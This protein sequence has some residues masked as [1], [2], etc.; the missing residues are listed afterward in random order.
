[1]PARCSNDLAT[2]ASSARVKSGARG[3]EEEMRRLSLAL[4]PGL[5]S[6]L[7]YLPTGAG[8]GKG[9]PAA[10]DALHLRRRSLRDDAA[11]HDARCASGPG[12]PGETDFVP[13]LVTGAHGGRSGPILSGSRHGRPALAGPPA[14]LLTCCGSGSRPSSHSTSAQ[15]F[16]P[17]IGSAR[18]LGQATVR[19]QDAG[20]LRLAAVD[21]GGVAGSALHSHHPRWPGRDS[22]PE[23][24]V[25]PKT[26][27]GAARRWMTFIRNARGDSAGIAY[28]LEIRYEDLLSDTEAT[29]RK[30]LR[31]HRPCRGRPHP[32]YTNERATAGGVQG[33]CLRAHRQALH[34]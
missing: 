34:R 3:A 9:P 16:G 17:F 22:F 20:I 2:N 18:A 32:E 8:A 12:H 15:R 1:M 28:Y 29:L 10:A 24:Q 4:A 14:R 19:R 7:I 6:S 13:D 26:I 5:R 11:A 31:F 23:A 33:L 21:S 27:A 25:G 30:V